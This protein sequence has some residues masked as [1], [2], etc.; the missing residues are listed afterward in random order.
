MKIHYKMS[1]WWSLHSHWHTNKTSSARQL[2]E[3]KPWWYKKIYNVHRNWIALNMDE[4]YI[5]QLEVFR[6]RFYK[7][8]HVLPPLIRTNMREIVK[9]LSKVMV[10]FCLGRSHVLEYVVR[11]P[12]IASD[13]SFIDTI[14]LWSTRTFPSNKVFG[15]FSQKV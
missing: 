1:Y 6:V 4:K 11:S 8:L 5:F 12:S 10:Q 3:K 15:V 2:Q 7:S 9:L 14:E 13:A